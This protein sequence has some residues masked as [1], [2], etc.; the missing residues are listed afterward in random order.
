M[1]QYMRGD[2]LL[3]SVALDERQVAKT[4]PVVVVST[5]GTGELRVCPVSSKP[6]SDAPCLPLSIDDFDSGGLDLFSESYVMT[7]RIVTIRT[8]G[9]I[10]KKGRL[11]AEFTDEIFRQVPVSLLSETKPEPWK[12]GRRFRR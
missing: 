6:P 4:R 2:V 12:N 9:V 8:G 5:T 7:S 1:G 10:G 11:R 3:A